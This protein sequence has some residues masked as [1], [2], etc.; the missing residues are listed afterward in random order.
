MDHHV[1]EWEKKFKNTHIYWCVIHNTAAHGTL[2]AFRYINIIKWFRFLDN[3]ERAVI[4]KFYCCCFIYAQVDKSLLFVS[5]LSGGLFWIRMSD[6]VVEQ[7][8][9]HQY[10]LQVDKKLRDLKRDLPLSFYI[11]FLQSSAVI[12]YCPVLYKAQ[13]SRVP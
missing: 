7:N 2:Q 6:W 4:Y 3:W 12:Q 9:F 1:D 11:V 13:Y 8:I 10:F 5:A